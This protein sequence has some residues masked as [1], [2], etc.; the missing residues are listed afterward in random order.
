MPVRT[1]FDNTGQPAVHR[2]AHRAI[3]QGPLI[4]LA[5]A[6]S[7]HHSLLSSFAMIGALASIGALP[8]S[9]HASPAAAQMA[10]SVSVAQATPAGSPALG[11]RIID[12]GRPDVRPAVPQAA[13]AVPPAPVQVE[14]ASRP[15]VTITDIV[16]LGRTSVPV[17]DLV[18]SVR[19]FAGRPLTADILRAIAAAIG[20]VY[21]AKG[22]ALYGVQLP[23]QDFAGGVVRLT[24]VEG[25]IEEVRIT[26]DLEGADTSLIRA[27]ADRVRAEHPLRQATLERALLLMNDIPGRKV[28]ANLEPIEG[29]A[30]AVRLV[31]SVKRTDVRFGYSLDNLGV[32]ELG[33]VQGN[34]TATVNGLL[35]EGDSTRLQYAFPTDFHRFTYL[36]GSHTQPIGTNGTTITG[37]VGWLRTRPD[38]RSRL[39]GEAITGSVQI[40]HPL[41]RSASETLQLFGRFDTFDSDTALLASQVSDEATR[42]L[43]AGT[44]YS[45]TDNERKAGLGLYFIASQGLDVLGARQGIVIPGDPD[46][47][48]FYGEPDFTKFSLLGVGVLPILDEKLILRLRTTLQYSGRRL[49]ASELFTYGGV[50]FGHGFS[51]GALTGDRAM[52]GSLTVAFPLRTVLQGALG[53]RFDKTELYG[54]VDG[55]RVENLYTARL[56]IGRNDR[57]ASAG[58]GVSIPVPFVDDTTASFEA[59][60]P[61]VI[62]RFGLQEDSWRF[63]FSI[64]RDI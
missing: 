49:P 38:D 58:V 21:K 57:A 55:T 36:A 39:D 48:L 26:G 3:F 20:D 51:P 12:S 17:P 40:S 43:R 45:Y 25:H 13:P 22:F 54:F 46:R 42:V 61:I 1:N 9:F 4:H 11:P 47:N 60:K 63:V 37:S 30:D 35:Q 15:D 31:L 14:G 59:A 19:P 44:S 34:L 52:A 2:T 18:S 6:R 28:E 8:V 53:E 62:P 33:R 5:E 56:I 64:R 24:V 10:G 27:H 7:H 29:R 32:H 16:L 41:I 23:Q 50:D